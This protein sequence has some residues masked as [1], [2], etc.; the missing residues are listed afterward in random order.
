[1]GRR[2]GDRERRNDVKKCCGDEI[3]M[4]IRLRDMS[5]KPC[6]HFLATDRHT[7]QESVS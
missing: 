3:S 4:S 2:R 1:M 7:V 5:L 6:N